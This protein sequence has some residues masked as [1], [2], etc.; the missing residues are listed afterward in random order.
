M[1]SS[2][3]AK[4]RFIPPKKSKTLVYVVMFVIMQMIVGK[5]MWNGLCG[6]TYSERVIH[7]IVVGGGQFV[8]VGFGVQ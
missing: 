1:R 3:R 2:W 8:A 5:V 4:Q 7:P 6:N